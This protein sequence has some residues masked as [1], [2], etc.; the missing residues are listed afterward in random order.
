MS[1]QWRKVD[2]DPPNEEWVI[3]CSKDGIISG[4]YE[5]SEHGVRYNGGMDATY[6]EFWAPIDAVNWPST[7]T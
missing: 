3:G 4:V 7:S 1:I 2:D 6:I 5:K